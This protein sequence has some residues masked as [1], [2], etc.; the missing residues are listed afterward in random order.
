MAHGSDIDPRYAAQFQRGFDPAQ[1]KAPPA[2]PPTRREPVRLEGGP[3]LTAPRVP[4][5]PPLAERPPA[6]PQMATVSEAE[7]LLP[8]GRPRLE[9]ALLGV[10]VALLV[11]AA[12][13]FAGAVGARDSG[14]GTGIED[15]LYGTLISQ[16]PG[17]L[18]VAGVLG[19]VLW[20]VVRAVSPGRRAG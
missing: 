18:L 9:S 7:D 4:D 3:P 15:Q 6:E 17:P 2:T 20:I 10:G 12:M 14:L 1:Q 8:P 13:L 19:I 16:L 5:S 11:L